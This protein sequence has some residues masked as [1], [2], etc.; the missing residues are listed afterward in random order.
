M[1]CWTLV[2]SHNKAQSR[3][4]GCN[5]NCQGIIKGLPKKMTLDEKQK[6]SGK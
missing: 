6:G 2:G 5:I 3:E 1:E 4:A